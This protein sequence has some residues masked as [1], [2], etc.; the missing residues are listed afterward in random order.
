MKKIW[1]F[2]RCGNNGNPIG[3]YG[4]QYEPAL[5]GNLKEVSHGECDAEFIHDEDLPEGLRYGGWWTLMGLYNPDADIGNEDGNI[6]TG[7]TDTVFLRDIDKVMKTM[8]EMPEDIVGSRCFAGG[9]FNTMLL[10]IRKGSPGAVKVWEACKAKNFKMDPRYPE[11]KFVRDCAAGHTAILPDEL[12]ASYKQCAGMFPETVR[13]SDVGTANVMVFHGHPR[14]HEVTP[15][16]PHEEL[17][18]SLWGKFYHG[19]R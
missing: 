13:K 7:G 17:I 3:D 14:P 9:G 6:Y 16:M 10:R 4:P 2:L 8:D 18:Y 5:R 1:T 12:T 11:F 15:G 19:P